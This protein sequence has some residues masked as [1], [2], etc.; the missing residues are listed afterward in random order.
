MRIPDVPLRTAG[1]RSGNRRRTLLLVAAGAVVFLLLFSSGI[2]AFYTDYLWYD[3]LDV[4]QVFTGILRARLLL[5]FT[6]LATSF[7]LVWG[8]LRIAERLGPKGPRRGPEDEVVQRYREVVGEQTG[9]VR[10]AAAGVLAFLLA[11]GVGGR[12]E[13]FLLFRNKVGFGTKDPQFGRDVSFYVFDLPFRTF[14]VNWLLFALILTT[15]VTTAFHYLNGGIRLQVAQQRGATP[16]VK[17]HISVLL[18][19]IAFVKAYSYWLERFELVYS[20]RGFAQGAFYTDV[21]ARLPALGLLTL[22]SVAAGV[23][24]LANIYRRGFALPAVSIGLW[25]FVTVLVGSALPAL[26]QQFKVKPAENRLETP[27]IQRNIDATRAAFGL[28]DIE[29]KSFEYTEA[30]GALTGQTLQD[31]AATIRNIRLWDPNKELAR[32]TWQQQQ[33]FRPYYQVLDV[34]VDRYE[35]NGQATQTVVATRELQPGQLP[36][37]NWVNRHL[38]YTHG[39]GAIIAPANAVTPDGFPA[40]TLKDLP[41]AGTPALDQPRIYVGEQ[42]DVAGAND[43]AIVGTKQPEIDFQRPDGSDETSSY[44]GRSGVE[45]GSSLRRLAF[46]VRYRELNV[47]TSPLITSESKVLYV[48]GVKERVRKMA[49]FLTLD[50]DPYPVVT[51]DNK[52]VWI[53]DAY[54]TT[55]RYPYSQSVNAGGN[56]EGVNYVRNS[57]KAAVD[58]YDGTVT[59][60]AID[61]KDPMLKAYSKTFPGLFTDPAT[62]RGPAVQRYESLREHFRYPEDLFRLQA[63]HL[64]RYHITNPTEFFSATDR[65]NVSP[66]PGVQATSERS[67]NST[68]APSAPAA[69]QGGLGLRSLSSGQD[70]RIP[71]TYQLQKFP[72]E[73]QER[74]VLTVPFVPFDREDKRLQLTAFLTA[75]SDPGE[76]GK[77]IL[78]R[79]PSGQQINGPSLVASTIEANTEISSQ[80]SLLNTQGSSVLFGN[81]L[82]V[83]IDKS[84]VYVRPL[85]VRAE[86]NPVPKL[87]KVIAVYGNRAIMRDTLGKALED[88]FPGAPSTLEQG[89]GPAPPGGSP[90][91]SSSPGETSGATLTDL[92]AG[93]D[94]AFV[95]AQAALV[96]GDL[97]E[98]QRKVNE[99]SG[100]VRQATE[101]AASAAPAAGT[102]PPS[103][104][105]AGA[106]TTTAAPAAITPTTASG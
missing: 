56:L 50:D 69:G 102:S 47:V 25:L 28:T 60:Y 19:S 5:I 65:W 59:L 81:I 74:F 105:P 51:A 21:K 82:L 24:L 53:V 33:S 9:K 57:V 1:G 8:N 92:V 38:A 73:S 83:P 18:A 44:A 68:R 106:T 42:G 34:D 43:Y 54:T 100:L 79:T 64:G 103:D 45:L 40:Y 7:L 37:D 30:A 71:P 3:D 90:P 91:G 29:V 10:L 16:Q 55:S 12:W 76:Y 17:A 27:Y 66:D 86:R 32:V 70:G 84:I 2:A 26:T 48:R 35:L 72:G 93:A 41:P 97:A 87:V 101:R 89:T 63:N 46:A 67:T 20:E 31:D 13:D 61:G 80:I 36:Q 58:A 6:F 94:A 85:Y 99:A 49:P 23:L 75:R 95:A 15:L 39:Y 11:A 22:I 4:A 96:R 98:Y 14:V 104:A 62:L 52:I 88:L 77:L 78:F